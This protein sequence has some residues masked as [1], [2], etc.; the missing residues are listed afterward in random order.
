MNK[1]LLRQKYLTTASKGLTTEWKRALFIQYYNTVI[2][3]IKQVKFK[4]DCGREYGLIRTVMSTGKIVISG[5]TKR[6]CCCFFKPGS[7][8]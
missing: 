5:L 2:N 8:L 7:H 4:L 6:G 1:T 3:P